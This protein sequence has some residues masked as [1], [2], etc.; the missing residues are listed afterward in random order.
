[1][2]NDLWETGKI[3]LVSLISAIGGG[4]LVRA[5]GQNRNEATANTVKL[6]EEL[7]ERNKDLARRIDA[8]AVQAVEQAAIS[9]E[10]RAK[11]G[12]LDLERTM[13]AQRIE[14]LA[15]Q[16]LAERHIRELETRGLTAERDQLVVRVASLEEQV[17][18]CHK[19]LENQKTM[20]EELRTI[21]T[22]QTDV[23]ERTA[24]LVA[25]DARE[26]A[27]ALVSSVPPSVDANTEAVQENT[28]ATQANTEARTNGDT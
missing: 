8:Q 7:D 12:Y 15:D 26:V 21:R 23:A 2:A 9:G 6:L 4:G 13:Q 14:G 27:K 28:A 24:L 16:V 5:F 1:M 11:L 3:A 17:I 20:L 10:N 25:G 22:G 18:N 19:V